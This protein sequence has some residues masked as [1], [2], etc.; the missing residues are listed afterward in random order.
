[1]SEASQLL[2]VGWLVALAFSVHS[3]D[4]RSTANDSVQQQTPL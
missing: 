4:G 3:I 2:L 1:M